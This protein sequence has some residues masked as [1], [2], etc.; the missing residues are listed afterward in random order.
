[1]NKNIGQLSSF[2]RY[3]IVALTSTAVDFSVLI[4][5]TEVLQFWYLF[6]AFLG[7]F[8]GG[9]TGFILGRNWVFK[10]KEDMLSTQAIRYLLVWVSSILLNTI[11][12]YL[13]VEFIGVQ[14]IISKIIVALVVGVVFNFLMHK[15]F[16]FK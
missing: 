4:F 7:A 13:V 6:S 1:M 11:G 2:Y 9:V 5:F 8:V 12:L 16:T 3:N 15:N 10:K 14:Y